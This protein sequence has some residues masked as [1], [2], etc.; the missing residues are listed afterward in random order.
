MQTWDYHATIKSKEAV[1]FDMWF[2][3]IEHALY[4]DEFGKNVD[5]INYP[6]KRVTISLINKNEHADI[7]DDI[8]TTQRESLTD[9]INSTFQAM[10]KN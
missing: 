3:E 10:Y 6:K 4:D 9:I 2:K 8:R 5:L 1:M 7:I